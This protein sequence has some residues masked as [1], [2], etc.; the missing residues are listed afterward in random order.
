MN[1]FRSRV[2]ASE[3]REEHDDE[4]S[5]CERVSAPELDEAPS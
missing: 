1:R 4:S 3:E 5:R 2:L